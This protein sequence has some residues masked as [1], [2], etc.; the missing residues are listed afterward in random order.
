MDIRF[1]G[2]SL[3]H[4]ERIL[5]TAVSQEDTAETIVPD[6]LPDVAELLMTDGQSLIRGK[7]VHHSGVS[8]SG[9]SELSVL[10]R[11]EEGSLGRLPVEIPFETEISFNIPDDSAKI[12]ASVRLT[13]C[14]ARILN[15]RKLLLRAE[16]CIT[17]SV[18]S[19]R[20]LRW[21]EEAAA[22]ECRVERKTECCVLRP[23]SEIVEK[24]F[25]A[26]DSQPMP[27]GRPRA[28]SLLSTRASL[29]WEEAEQVGRKLVV[30]GTAD[31]T[32][33]YRTLDDEA[34]TAEFR[35]PWSAFL[36][37]PETDK[38]LS[39]ELVTALTGCSGE[40]TEE[41]GFSI[42]VG[43][44]VQAVIR[45]ETEISWIADAYGIDCAFAPVFETTEMDT[46]TSCES[47]TEN[48]N[49]FLNSM[50]K[51]RSLVYLTA[52]C[53]RPRQDKENL[54]LPV[55]VKALCV[56]EDGR[57]E[58]LSGRGEMS[59]AGISSLPEVSCGEVFASVTPGGVELR[60]PVCIRQTRCSRRTLSLLTDAEVSERSERYQGPNVVLLRASDGDSVWSLGKKKGISCTAIR[61]YNQLE[62]G[63]EPA[64][65]SL[66]LLAR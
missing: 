64:P 21:A 24:T 30:R 59:F 18:W 35:L 40:L 42:A 9:I 55:N 6:A 43:G 46:A 2:A 14:E 26:E 36:E 33:L 23:V 13:G 48:L 32:A 17:V 57:P 7:D 34:A 51:P 50:R 44:V 4:Y 53:G 47:K 63:E 62:E 10:Y 16:T 58:Q 12:V 15:S 38:G 25:T 52:D 39:W 1:K 11:T 3:Q 19:Q 5:N 45:N 54:R 61:S 60:V 29:R 66:L 37:L 31:V 22:E 20:T 27:A 49:I 28:E 8:V 65:G 41:N 56:M